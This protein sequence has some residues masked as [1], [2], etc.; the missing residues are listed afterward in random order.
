MSGSGNVFSAL[1]NAKTTDSTLVNT[2]D[3]AAGFAGAAKVLEASYEWPWH[4]QGSIGPHAALADV[5]KD[6]AFVF[7][8]TQNPYGLRNTLA[9]TLGLPVTSIR[10]QYYEG[11]SNYGNSPWDDTA[12][13]AA[14]LSQAAGKPVRLQFMRWDEH[15]WAN[16]ANAQLFDVRG[17]VDANGKIVAYDFASFQPEWVI[18]A[19]SA[20]LAGT[21]TGAATPI[22]FNFTENPTSGGGNYAIPNR[23]V[24]SKGVSIKSGWPRSSYMRA[25]GANSAL[26]ASEQMIDEL[27]HAISMD[28]LAFRKQN[29]T[30]PRWIALLDAVAKASSWQAKPAASKLSSAKVVSGRGIAIGGYVGTR[31]AVVADIEVNRKTGKVTVKHLCGAQDCG[32]AVNPASVEN[33]MLGGMVQMASRTLFESY[34]FT[35]KHVTGLDWVSYP[36]MRIK[37]APKVTTVVVQRTDAVA[38]GSGEPASA[39]V[40][41]A[42]ANAFFD[43]TGVRVRSLPLTPVRVRALL[44]APS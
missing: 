3:V 38:T 39:P 34:A 42:I 30:E 15:G 36:I 7:A 17:G 12:H 11:S 2:G 16:G 6:S 40:G 22:Y 20:E 28:P 26:F 1:R 21:A 33:Q 5:R 18:S 13:A 31:A 27:A 23:R 10:V 14:I 32:L 4:I 24:M 43:A 25:P 29:I 8:A 41:A 9:V 37:D 44:A 35:K 19:A